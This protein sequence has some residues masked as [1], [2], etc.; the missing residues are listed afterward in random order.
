[1]AMYLPGRLQ[2]S[3]RNGGRVFLTFVADPRTV[4]L[5]RNFSRGDDHDTGR[6]GEVDHLRVSSIKRLK[7][8]AQFQD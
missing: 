8:E 4:R 2:N 3:H 7:S 1:M 6:V 5:F